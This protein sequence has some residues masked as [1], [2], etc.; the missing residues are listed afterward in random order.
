MAFFGFYGLNYFV[1][2]RGSKK[3]YRHI[4]LAETANA[5][6]CILGQ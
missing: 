5:Q 1:F 4:Q 2:K 6:A 3:D